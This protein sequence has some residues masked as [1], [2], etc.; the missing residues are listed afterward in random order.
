MQT[1]EKYFRTTQQS[2][3][4]YKKVEND[5]KNIKPIEKKFI[6]GQASLRELMEL[7]WKRFFT[8]YLR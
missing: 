3:E 2:R 6:E 1:E 8:A 7:E 4:Y 5:L